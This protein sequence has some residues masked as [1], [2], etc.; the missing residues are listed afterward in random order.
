MKWK[1]VGETA[2]K[3]QIVCGAAALDITTVRQE[4]LN[5]KS[6]EKIK[7]QLYLEH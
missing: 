2:A 7:P 4:D 5:M 3:L 1:K 6:F